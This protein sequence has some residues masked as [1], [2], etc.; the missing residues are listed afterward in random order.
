[1]GPDPVCGNGLG[2]RTGRRRNDPPYHR[3]GFSWNA[4]LVTADATEIL[5]NSHNIDILAM[6]TDSLE[7]LRIAEQYGIMSI[8]YNIDNNEHYPNTFLTAPVW[9]WENYY[10]PYILKCLQGKFEG[11]NYWEGTSAGV[12]GLA[13]LS[14]NVKPGIEEQLREAQE[15]LA[16]GNFDVFYGP[17]RDNQGKLRVAEGENMSDEAMLNHM[18]WYVEGVVI[19]E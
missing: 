9:Q 16:R 7:P 10:E 15:E 1:L 6:H 5:I 12:V 2:G 4:D 8:G 18:D 11:E 17:V 14:K 13:P 3:A 19:H